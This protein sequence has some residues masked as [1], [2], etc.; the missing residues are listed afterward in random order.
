MKHP[1]PA[2]LRMYLD[3]ELSPGQL[4]DVKQHLANC[5]ACTEQLEA[6]AARSQRV[7]RL[8]S[9]LEPD[10]AQAAHPASWQLKQFKKKEMIPVKKTFALPRAAWAALTVVVVLAVALAFQPVRALAGNLLG[11]FRVQQVTTLAVD[12][13]YLNSLHRTAGE[14]ISKLF[15]DSVQETRA[16]QEPQSAKDAV[17]A[18]ELAGFAVRELL[19]QDDDTEYSVDFGAAFTFTVDVERAN[20][21]LEAMGS[22]SLKLPADVD[23]AQVYVDVPPSVSA[24]L[25]CDYSN[26][27]ERNKC[28]SFLQMPSPSI[29]TDSPV[30]LPELAALGLQVMGLDEAEA[31]EM[32]AT[33]DWQSTL[34]IPIPY[35]GVEA[36]T[37]TLD[38]VSG[39]LLTREMGDISE[40]ALVW[41]RDGMLYVLQGS[42]DPQYALSLVGG[43]Q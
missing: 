26:E 39:Q 32:A 37:I 1:S 22:G 17:Q 21:T 43:S 31:V 9:H 15:N 25:P 2:D 3:H 24:Y 28:L 12:T 36:Q 29:T 20:A 40:F 8:L 13:S 7:Q 14:A 19:P 18:G 4:M 16:W 30:D 10:A 41:A 11:L 5:R 6:Q 23:G 27:T 35:G 42:G 34:V 38:G 33:I